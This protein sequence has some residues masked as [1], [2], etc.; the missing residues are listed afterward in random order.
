MMDWLDMANAPIKPAQGPDVETALAIRC[1]NL[2][3]GQLDW[4][5]LPHVAEY[6]GI[7]DVDGLIAQLETIRRHGQPERTD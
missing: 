7:A 4:N 5:A 6:V 1:W 3:G 2:L